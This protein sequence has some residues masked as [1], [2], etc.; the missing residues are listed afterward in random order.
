MAETISK[1]RYCFYNPS[2]GVISIRLSV[3]NAIIAGSDFKLYSED[4][5]KMLEEFKIS[6]SFEKEGGKL[7]QTFPKDLNKTNLIW[8]VICCSKNAAIYSSLVKVV[9]MQEDKELKMTFPAEKHLV[10][11][12]PCVVQKTDAYNGS[13]VFMAKK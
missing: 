5:S 3:G 8:S 7:V 9:I 6:A 13:L 10:N 12:P 2:G 4:K 11:I 1:T